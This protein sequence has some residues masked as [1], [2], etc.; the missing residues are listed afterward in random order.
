[1]YTLVWV[2]CRTWIISNLS[3]PQI[4]KLQDN[5]V[6]YPLL[7]FPLNLIQVSH[8]HKDIVN[9][10]ALKRLLAQQKK[11]PGAKRNS[12]LD[13]MKME[14]YVH[15]LCLHFSMPIS[16]L[17]I[18]LQPQ[19]LC[20]LCKPNHHPKLT[21]WHCSAASTSSYRKSWGLHTH[22]RAI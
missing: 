20:G 19:P 12:V 4:R 7:C 6:V 14:F 1:M 15:D 5:N 21:M 2:I 22:T 8:R 3:V 11:E 16:K 17:I 13:R 9:G 18:T 10:I